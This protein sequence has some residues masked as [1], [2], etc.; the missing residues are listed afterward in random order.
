MNNV[1]LDCSGLHNIKVDGN[2]IPRSLPVDAHEL[3]KVLNDF[4]FNAQIQQEKTL[5]DEF[6]MRAMQGIL[7]NRII[8]DREIL[9]L[10]KYVYTIADVMMRK[11]E[12]R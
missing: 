3:D 9:D 11:R 2:E 4:L 6:A 1:Y 12:A 5:R 8:P 7:S 10:A